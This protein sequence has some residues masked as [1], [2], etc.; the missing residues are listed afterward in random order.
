MATQALNANH[1]PE[2]YGVFGR[3]ESGNDTILYT[4]RLAHSVET[5]WRAISDPDHR[6]A[7]FP[8]LTL[9]DKLGGE[10][11]VNFSGG[12]CPPPE[13]N[14]SD[15]YFCVITRYEPPHLLEYEGN[16]EHHRF[17]IEPTASGCTLKFLATVPPRDDFDDSAQTIQTRYSVACGWHYKLDAME[18]DLDGIAFEDEGYA[19]PIKTEYYLRY[20][21]LDR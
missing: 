8:E 21:K 16:G 17:E 9:Q 18:W 10:A 3:D 4:R 15:V 5:V 14:P 19:G 7:W 11:V 12:D 6:A 13:D 1:D 20:R 2:R